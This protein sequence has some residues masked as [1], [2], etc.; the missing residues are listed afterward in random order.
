[1]EMGNGG[2][3]LSRLCRADA[4]DGVCKQQAG[5]KSRMRRR[6]VCRRLQQKWLAAVLVAIRHARGKI[7]RRID[8]GHFPAI[9]RPWP[10]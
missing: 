1:M 3:R 4:G 2:G 10:S 8:D 7:R 9:S 6:T 5:N